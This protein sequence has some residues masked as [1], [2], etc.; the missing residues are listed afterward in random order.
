MDSIK[1]VDQNTTNV[2][3][4]FEEQLPG[5]RIQHFPT[6][7]LSDTDGTILEEANPKPT[8]DGIKDYI[9]GAQTC[10]EGRK[11]YTNDPVPYFWSR[12]Y[13]KWTGEP[14]Q[15]RPAD[16]TGILSD[17][18]TTYVDDKQKKECESRY[19]FLRREAYDETAD[20]HTLS[21]HNWQKQLKSQVNL[22]S[23]GSNDTQA[24]TVKQANELL[25]KTARDKPKDA[26]AIMSAPTDAKDLHTK[27]L[28]KHFSGKS[29]Q[30]GD[31]GFVYVGP[32]AGKLGK[33]QGKGTPTA[34][35]L[36]D[37][38]KDVNKCADLR[39]RADAPD[40]I[41]LKAA[42]K[43]KYDFLDYKGKEPPADPPADPPSGTVS[44]S[45]WAASWATPPYIYGA[46]AV[47]AVGGVYLGWDYFF[48]KKTAQ[49]QP[50][51]DSKAKI[52]KNRP[53]RKI[54]K[55]NQPKK[56]TGTSNHDAKKG[57]RKGTDESKS[58]TSWFLI[59]TL[60]VLALAAV[61]AVLYF[62]VFSK[63][64][65]DEDEDAAS[66][67]FDDVENR[68]PGYMSGSGG[69]KPGNDPE[70][71]FEITVQAPAADSPGQCFA[72]AVERYQAGTAPAAGSPT[73]DDSEHI[74]RKLAEQLAESSMSLSNRTQETSVNSAPEAAELSTRS[75]SLQVR[76]CN[77]PP[78][79]NAPE[80]HPLTRFKR[81]TSL[82]GRWR[83]SSTEARE[84]SG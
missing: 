49:P 16:P 43:K 21:D 79:V 28:Y 37:V 11:E 66:E 50:A 6:M 75:D 42:C 47:A 34:A 78:P 14:A 25:L 46:V 77:I 35:E 24:E 69:A 63:S 51:A 38:V 23:L 22:V 58:G 73:S 19:K 62:F 83:K 59:I 32:D 65:D 71:P 55:R 29:S 68:F 76:E 52:K 45:T 33:Y 10:M 26:K 2:V 81:N 31:K 9:N 61:G 36:V 15:P 54:S 39:T 70:K 82:N 53:D 5:G 7:I 84:L 27:R 48:G 40:N 41:D 3:K 74:K 20:P 44:W 1:Y 72:S 17:H 60:I 67:I 18:Y 13:S 80:N 30:M 64:G 4:H 57:D 8:A 56:T 12:W